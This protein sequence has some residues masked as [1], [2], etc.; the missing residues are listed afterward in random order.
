[1]EMRRVNILEWVPSPVRMIEI[2]RPGKE[3]RPLG[4]PTIKD[5]VFQFMV[6]NA[7]EAEW[8][9]LFEHRSYGFTVPILQWFAYGE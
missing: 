7:L 8:E 4:I 9:A 2:P 1:M 6:K 5:R 3:P